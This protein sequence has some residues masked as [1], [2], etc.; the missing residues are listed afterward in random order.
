MKIIVTHDSPDVDAVTSVWLIKKFLPGW[1]NAKIQFVPAGERIRN[2]KY[3]ISNIKSPIEKLGDD[4]VIHVDTGLGPLD[5]H[6]TA[7]DNVCGASLTWDFVRTNGSGFASGSSERVKDKI[8]AI[9]R[10]IRVV[11]DIDH[12]KEV[13]WPNPTADYYDFALTSILDG[14]K[15]QKPN[16]NSYYVE[17]ISEV[18]DAILHEFEN[19]IWA[20]KEI[21]KNGKKF[22]TRFGEG[23][24][25]ETIND[26]VIKLAQKMGYVI[27][28]RKDPRKG[29][30]RIKALPKHSPRSL[31]DSSKPSGNTHSYEEKKASSPAESFSKYNDKDSVK[32]AS[33]EGDRVM[34]SRAKYIKEIDLTLVYEKLKKIDPDATWY[35]HISKKML[36]NGSVKNPKMRPTK[37]SLDEIIKVLKQI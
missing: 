6:Q 28:L 21:S 19:R 20:E 37:L 15:I 23:I 32:S 10:I 11:V 8:E 14:L 25:F 30:V 5:H 34:Y 13:F 12:F 35:L 18:L 9:S 33:R 3:K 16:K 27:A 17:F 7:D 24:G 36:L 4:E 31:N 22:K 2:I 26:S 29:Y 1:E